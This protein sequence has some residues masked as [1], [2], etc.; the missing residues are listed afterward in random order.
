MCLLSEKQTNLC[1]DCMQIQDLCKFSSAG[2]FNRYH[3][4]Q[5]IKQQSIYQLLMCPDSLVKKFSLHVILTCIW[6]FT[7]SGSYALFMEFLFLGSQFAWWAGPLR[8][9]S[10]A[11]G[12][13]V[14]IVIAQAVSQSFK[15][16]RLCRIALPCF[17]VITCFY[18]MIRLCRSVLQQGYLAPICIDQAMPYQAALLLQAILP[19]ACFTH[20][21]V[22]WESCV[23]SS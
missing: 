14:V 7:M 18:A 21:L 1:K 22:N 3:F 19:R 2:P 4:S 9:Q 5:G 23:T 15:Y 8:S 16:Y 17:W 13:F 6:D 10:V 11:G 20:G 12:L